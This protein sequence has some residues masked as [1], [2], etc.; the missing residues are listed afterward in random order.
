MA[1]IND[2]EKQCQSQAKMI[3]AWLESGKTL[4]RLDAKNLFGCFEL[5]A[6]I[7][8]LRDKGMKIKSTRVVFPN[9]KRGCR[10]SIG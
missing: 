3:R 9:G 10:Y 1:N 7:C 5:S 6:R 2:N 8:E 4:T